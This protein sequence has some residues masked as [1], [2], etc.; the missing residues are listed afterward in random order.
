MNDLCPHLRAHGCKYCAAE[1]GAN[2]LGEVA[3]MR[4]LQGRNAMGVW[5]ESAKQ[6]RIRKK[7]VHRRI[8][9]ARHSIRCIYWENT[10]KCNCGATS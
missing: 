5:P 2:E 8:D 6:Y 1:N 3:S 4:T 7:A 10:N 9:Q